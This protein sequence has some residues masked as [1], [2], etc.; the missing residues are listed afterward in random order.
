MGKQIRM[1]KTQKVV[2]AMMKENTGAHFLD[3]GGAYGRH[4]SR[5][6]ARD[7]MRESSATLEIKKYGERAEISV[8]INLFYF[9]SNALEYDAETQNKLDEYSDENP[10]LYGTQLLESFIKSVGGRWIGS[11]NSY[12]SE[13]MLSQDFQYF[14]W[15]DKDRYCCAFIQVHGGCDILSGYTN[16]KCFFVKDESVFYSMD[17]ATI[18][19]D[20]GHYW[21]S[22]SYGKWRNNSNSHLPNLETFPVIKSD[23]ADEIDL[24]SV[25]QRTREY[26]ALN[27]TRN[28][29][30]LFTRIF[31]NQP[32]EIPLSERSAIIIDDAGMPHCPICGAQLCA[33]IVE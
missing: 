21:D 3:S 15:D 18:L 12:N 24:V 19:C 27:R 7:F 23:G 4:W 11:D 6:Q 10:E 1:N 32:S 13:N 33:R 26:N 25:I 9:L 29:N 28:K 22:E 14:L 17:R 16:P 5:N 2:A 20:N 31:G 8:S 30:K